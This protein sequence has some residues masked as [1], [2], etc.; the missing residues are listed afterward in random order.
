VAA[1]GRAALQGIGQGGCFPCLKHAPG[2]GRATA[3][4]HHQL[5]AVAAP[6]AALD[7]DALPFKALA[8]QSPFMMTAH[9]RYR[10]WDAD[11]P[12][13]CSAKIIQ[14]MRQT[15]S[16]NGL[17]VADD[18]G[19]NALDGDYAGRARRALAA[20]CD[21]LICSLSQLRQGMAGTIYDEASA[22]AL[23]AMTLP[24]LGEGARAF[25]QTLT[26]P[27]APAPAAVAEARAK[28]TALMG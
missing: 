26:L 7:A 21:L 11:S 16:F 2:H 6:V 13:T 8:P 22:A 19:M 25:L 15:W 1:L 3:D 4:S 5:P 28:L 9:I 18:L 14:M 17:I 24:P 12:A 23:A 27:S 20:G 10:A